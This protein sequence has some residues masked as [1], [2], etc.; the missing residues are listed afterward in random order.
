MEGGI[1]RGMDR[2]RNG[3]GVD[4]RDG[5]GNGR[6][7]LGMKGWQWGM[8]ERWRGKGLEKGWRDGMSEREGGTE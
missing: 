6:W 1:R 2:R 5:E 8:W 7:D 4:L 3:R